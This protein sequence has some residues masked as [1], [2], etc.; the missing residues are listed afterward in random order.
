MS[1]RFVESRR[2]TF[3]AG[4]CGGLSTI[5]LIPRRNILNDMNVTKPDVRHDWTILSSARATKYLKH[6][7]RFLE[8]SVVV[9]SFGFRTRVCVSRSQDQIGNVAARRLHRLKNP[10]KWLTP[11]E[12]PGALPSAG[13]IAAHPRNRLPGSQSKCL[14][15]FDKRRQ[16]GIKNTPHNPFCSH[17]WRLVKNQAMLQRV[18]DSHL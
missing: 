9:D 1:G 14:P 5:G 6:K 10:K 17:N 8:F 12:A 7:A 3:D 4:Q 11:Q 18:K 15:F 16:A 2:K 13:P